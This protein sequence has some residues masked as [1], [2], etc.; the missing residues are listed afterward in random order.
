MSFTFGNTF[1]VENSLQ[2]IEETLNRLYPMRERELNLKQ[3]FIDQWAPVNALSIDFEMLGLT[4][5]PIDLTDCRVDYEAVGEGQMLFLTTYVS[6]EAM[7]K[8]AEFHQLAKQNSATTIR[9]LQ[10]AILFD[11]KTSEVVRRSLINARKNI[12]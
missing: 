8:D 3:R 12:K 7:D 6:K 9:G 5:M 11:K 4:E 2:S 1:S 10:A